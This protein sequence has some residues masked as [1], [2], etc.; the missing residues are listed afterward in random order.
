MK[1]STT[2]SAAAAA[3]STPVLCPQMVDAL[4][5][6]LGEALVQQFQRDTA[7]M[8]KSV[9]GHVHR[10]PATERQGIL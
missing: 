7:A 3:H 9:G 6:I 4:A 2:L 8:D 5:R 10:E 1:T